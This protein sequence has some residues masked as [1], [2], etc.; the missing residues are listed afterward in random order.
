MNVLAIG[1]TSGIVAGGSV[2]TMPAVYILG[3]E[4]L[5][6]FDLPMISSARSTSL[7]P[8]STYSLSSKKHW[9]NI[10]RN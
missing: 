5:M 3:L 6:S 1:A 10:R 2:F 9:K 4:G 8:A 7:A